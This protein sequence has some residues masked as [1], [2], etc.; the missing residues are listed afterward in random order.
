M[1]FI[2]ENWMALLCLLGFFGYGAITGYFEKTIAPASFIIMLVL[3]FSGFG[4]G[5]AIRGLVDVFTK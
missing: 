3:V 2:I 5:A 1:T 4:L